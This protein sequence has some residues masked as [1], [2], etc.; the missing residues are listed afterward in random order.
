MTKAEIGDHL[1]HIIES[2]L[3]QER[4]ELISRN[5]PNQKQ[6]LHIRNAILEIFNECN[7]PVNQDLKAVAESRINGNKVDL[8]LINRN[9]LE[10]PFKVEFKFQFSKDF[11]RF[12]KYRSIIEKDYE[13]R[14]S[15]AFVLIIA[16]WDKEL[17]ADFDNE[18]KI[19]PDLNQ[20]ICHK[21]PEQ[22]EWKSNI[23]EHLKSFQPATLDLREKQVKEP[24]PITYSFY[25]ISRKKAEDLE[26]VDSNEI[27]NALEN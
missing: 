9:E 14:E 2:P 27:Y 15:D 21:N 11:N 16:H 24:Y 17:K 25:I 20:Y 4:L 1:L 22:A 23:E 13:L 10:N 6:E 3:L 5:Y 7:A 8:C 19:T 18:W 12:K 26:L